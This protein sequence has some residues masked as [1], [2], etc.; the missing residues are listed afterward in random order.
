MD[1]LATNARNT[2]QH[3]EAWDQSEAT[4][5]ITAARS[6]GGATITSCPKAVS[7]LG[8]SFSISS[9]VR[10]GI[11]YSLVGSVDLSPDGNFSVRVRIENATESE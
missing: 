1:S 9:G 3:A 10:G 5:I 2:L 6:G 8:Q 11:M 7:G 4:K